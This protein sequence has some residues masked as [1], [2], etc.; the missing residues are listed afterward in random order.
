MKQ[1]PFRLRL[2]LEAVKVHVN[3]PVS[4]GQSKSDTM[5]ELGVVLACL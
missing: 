5:D 3:F 1:R 4:I 2:H